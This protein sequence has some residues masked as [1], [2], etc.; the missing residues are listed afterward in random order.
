MRE[1]GRK[2]A[3]SRVHSRAVEEG[4]LQKGPN[5]HFRVGA[6]RGRAEIT[7][8]SVPML[9]SRSGPIGGLASPSLS[10]SSPRVTA[11][12]RRG[13]TR[14]CRREARGRLP[15]RRSGG[16]SGKRRGGRAASFRA[17]RCLLPN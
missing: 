16:L 1:K 4:I 9:I 12:G 2:A 6:G 3:P 11:R 8:M 10:D 14:H 7:G 5:L 17:A 15:R 13:L